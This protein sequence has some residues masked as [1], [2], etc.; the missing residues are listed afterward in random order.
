[1]QRLGVIGIVLI[2]IYSLYRKNNNNNHESE[3]TTTHLQKST[4]AKTYSDVIIYVGLISIDEPAA[5]RHAYLFSDWS[6]SPLKPNQARSFR[7]LCRVTS[8]K[9][10]VRSAAYL[11]CDALYSHLLDHGSVM[12]RL[13]ISVH[14]WWE[15][16]VRSLCLWGSTCT[17]PAT[18]SRQRSTH[19]YKAANA[20]G[21]Y[22]RAPRSARVSVRRA[23]GVSTQQHSRRACRGSARRRSEHAGAAVPAACHSLGAAEGAGRWPG[24]ATGSSELAILYYS[25]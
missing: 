21:T 14:I 20:T 24:S 4:P 11:T 9:F 10:L 6:G 17:Q 12:E 8:G 18:T 16:A 13:Y 25:D 7:H 5:T 23:A 15:A 3:E 22:V 19:G 1:L 2:L